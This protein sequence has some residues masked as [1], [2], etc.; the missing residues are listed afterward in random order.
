MKIILNEN[1]FGVLLNE[2]FSEYNAYDGNAYNN[3]YT[4]KI[5]DAKKSLE[6]LLF[7]SGIVMVN[8]QN[9]KEY[10]IY[11]LKS[12]VNAI[13]KRYCL[14]QLIKDGEQYGTIATK[15]LDLFKI[16]NY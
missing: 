6:T 15:P 7:N 5:N 3:P 14:C 2:M 4:K 13:G 11:E 10:L 16:K 9:G 12:L 1:K 8:I